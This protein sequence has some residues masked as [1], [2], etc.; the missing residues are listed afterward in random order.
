[1]LLP[2]ILVVVILKCAP[3]GQMHLKVKK[4]VEL[5]KLIRGDDSHDKDRCEFKSL[6]KF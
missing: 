6:S 5:F 1:M 3:L 2:G 4:R